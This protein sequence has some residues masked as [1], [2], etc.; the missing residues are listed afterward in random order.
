MDPTDDMTEAQERRLAQDEVIIGALSA[1]SNYSNAGELAGTSSRTVARRMAD[2]VFARRVTER[3][4]EQV[5]VITGQLTGL[6]PEAIGA[7][8]SCLTDEKASVRVSAG[9]IALELGLR[10]RHQNDLELQV[11]EIRA[12]LGLDGV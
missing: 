12:H 11:A 2:P 4:A 3:R 1:G 9:K 5:Q 10:F 8:R 6:G 7:I